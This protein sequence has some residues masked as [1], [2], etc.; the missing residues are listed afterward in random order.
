MKPAALWYFESIN[1]YK[2]L[3]P[4]KLKADEGQHTYLK[5]QKNDFIYFENQAADSLYFVAQGKVKIYYHAENGDEMVKSIL[6]SGEIFGELALAEEEKRSEFAQAMDNNTLICV[7]KLEDIKH[8]LLDNKELSF[9]LV[10]LMGLKLFKMQRK[11]DLLIFKDTRTRVIEFL[12]DAAEW[13]GKKVGTETLIMTPLTHGD[14]AKLVG[15][16]RQSVST[17]LNELKSENLIYFDRKRILIRDL[18]LFH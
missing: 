3:C 4:V 5:C 9:K 7:W 11:I 18:A 14:I 1:L 10:K 13:K 15:L 17:V 6:S 8:L 2:V 12:R 16:S